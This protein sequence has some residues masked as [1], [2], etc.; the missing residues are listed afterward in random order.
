[1][2]VIVALCATA[3]IALLPRALQSCG[4]ANRLFGISTLAKTTPHWFFAGNSRASFVTA[5]VA[6]FGCLISRFVPAL[7]GTPARHAF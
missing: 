2:E 5:G 6:M 7:R 3:A 1:M 4:C